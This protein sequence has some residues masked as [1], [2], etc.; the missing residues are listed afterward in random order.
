MI[1]LSYL[2]LWLLGLLLS[3]AL[4]GLLLSGLFPQRDEGREFLG[5]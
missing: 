4:T 1:L 3:A 2:A 5:G